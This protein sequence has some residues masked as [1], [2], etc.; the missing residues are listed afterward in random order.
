MQV[1][2]EVGDAVMRKATT[3][4]VTAASGVTPAVG[5]ADL[6]ISDAASPTAPANAWLVRLL[7]DEAAEAYTGPFVVDRTHPLA[8]GLPLDGVVWGGG[9]SVESPGAPVVL[10]GGVPLLTDSEGP[11]GRH[12]VRLRWRADLS[13]LQDSPAWPVLMANLL[14]WRAANVPG[15]SRPNLRLGE[16]AV[17]TLASAVESARVVD[18]KGVG[19]AAVVRGNR[20]T[21]H[22]DDV[23][24]HEVQA[25][26]AKYRFAVNALSRDESDLG[27][28]ASG[29]WGDWLDESFVREE[30]Q[31]VGWVVLLGVLGVLAL[32]LFLVARG[33]RQLA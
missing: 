26:S 22:C 25:G 14:R 3:R 5:P 2:V 11:D 8:D 10:A 20:V 24:I 29:R 6:L 19:R 13:T 4:A 32:H 23:G 31:E 17:V 28:C 30:Y 15:A 1:A 33:G 7:R 21:A 27:R 16:D 9:K 18:S 12:D